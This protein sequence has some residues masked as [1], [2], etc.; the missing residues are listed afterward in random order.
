M[1]ISLARA[2]PS[3]AIRAEA[4][5]W[6]AHLRGPQRDAD[7]ERGFRL[8]LEAKPEHA[9]AFELATEIWERTGAVQRHQHERNLKWPKPQSGPVIHMAAMVATLAAIAVAAAVW[10]SQRG[11]VTTAVGEQRTITL[12]DGSRIYL[13]TDTRAVV[14]YSSGERLIR[15]DRGE[16][17]FQVA[18]DADRPFIVAAGMA[19]V[20]ALGT[21]FVVRR[22][23]RQLSV[24]L[25]EGKV[26]IVR[27]ENSKRVSH[28]DPPRILRPGERLTLGAHRAPILDAPVLD[29]MTAWQRGQVAFDSIL[30]ADAVAEMNRYSATK[31]M[32][33]RPEAA[34]VAIGG[35]FRAGDAASFAQAMAETYRLKVLEEPGRITL[36][37]TP[38]IPAL[39]NQRP[40]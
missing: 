16:A 22:D 4:A 32:I 6:L 37:G 31:L 10:Y 7:V 18:K 33:E 20:E 15:L 3:A 9:T 25:V 28:L 12:D 34:A 24:T 14:Q 21:S 38:Q 5:L 36:S 27:T 2:S 13:N 30:L 1:N 40:E 8:W 17:I 19:Q 11:S 23:Q 26:S 29:K 39:S 35:I